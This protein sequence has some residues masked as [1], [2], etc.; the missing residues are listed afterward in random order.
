VEGEDLVV[1]AAVVGAGGAGDLRAG[2]PRAGR[3]AAVGGGIVVQRRAGPLVGPGERVAGD[4][5]GVVLLGPAPE[6][7][8]RA[9]ALGRLGALV[10]GNRLGVRGL[11]GFD[12]ADVLG[13]DDRVTGAVG[14]GGQADGVLARVQRAAGAGGLVAVAARADVGVAG[15]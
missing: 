10:H 12:A 6:G 15:R 11:E 9:G 1:G 7:P 2:R 8:Q 5:E 3:R 4:A 13:Q 14:E